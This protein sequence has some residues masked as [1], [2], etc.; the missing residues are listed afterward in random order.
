M[1]RK[2]VVRICVENIKAMSVGSF[3]I[4]LYKSVR[5]SLVSREQAPGCCYISFPGCPSPPLP[6]PGRPVWDF[7]FCLELQFRTLRHAAFCL[8]AFYL[9]FRSLMLPVRAGKKRSVP[10][11]SGFSPV[12][13]ASRKMLCQRK[14]PGLT[15]GASAPGLCSGFTVTGP[16]AGHR[17]VIFFVDYHSN[18]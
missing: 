9:S 5:W 17:H 13:F 11:L 16:F 4:S 2:A 6:R 15:P 7:R 14:V 1:S 18:V 10:P 8:F 3:S 12:G